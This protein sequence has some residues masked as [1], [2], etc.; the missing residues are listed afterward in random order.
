MTKR[1]RQSM[2]KANRRKL[3]IEAWGREKAQGLP[4]AVFCRAYGLCRK[5]FYSW[6]KAGGN[7]APAVPVRRSDPALK[8]KAVEIYLRYKGTWGAETI[9]I[10]LEGRLSPGVVRAAIKPY[11]S[12]WREVRAPR[13]KPPQAPQAPW[14]P[15]LVW[16]ID[17]TEY[18]LRGRKIFIV[19][20]LDEA[21]RFFLGWRIVE[22]V[23]GTED[24]CAVVKDIL[25]RF[26][27]RPLLIKSDR[28]AV[29]LSENWEALLAA[30]GMLP[31]RVR[32]RSPW[33]QGI[34]E[35]SIREVKAWLRAKSPRSVDEF[36]ACVD[37]G[38]LML[39]F[40]KPRG[41]LAGR[42]PARAHFPCLKEPSGV[43]ACA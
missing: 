41:V 4:L 42:T 3:F 18:R 39:N 23:P 1:E 30:N 40:L 16:S 11:R 37:E 38:M 14:L 33:E 34:I 20:V 5:S 2:V 31:H 27:G 36:K 25:A 21:S 10:A 12:L 9:S 43:P 15:N 8:C 22:R 32:P 6:L 24:V 29:F 35:R 7:P 19:V 13:E 26:K 28:A 17:W